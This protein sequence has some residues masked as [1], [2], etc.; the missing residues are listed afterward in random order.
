[1]L[2][3]FLAV[4]SP[5]TV[6]FTWNTDHSVPTSGG[7]YACCALHCRFRCYLRVCRNRSLAVHQRINCNKWTERN[8]GLNVVDGRHGSGSIKTAWRPLSDDN[9]YTLT[10]YTRQLR[11]SFA[12]CRFDYEDAGTSITLALW[13]NGLTVLLTSSAVAEL[14]AAQYFMSLNM[15]MRHSRSGMCKSY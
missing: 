8:T 10:E 4:I 13:R 1:M 15:S 9:V 6:W 12:G 3:S 7:G 14:W 11:I 5:Q 2:K